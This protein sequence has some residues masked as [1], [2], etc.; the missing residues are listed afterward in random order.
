MAASKD[1]AMARSVLDAPHLQSEEAAFEYI[2]RLIWPNGP[3][4]PWSNKKTGE[5]CASK[6]QNVVKLTVYAKPKKDGTRSLRHG[7]YRCKHCR[8][9]FTVRKGTVF[10]ETQ[11]PMHLWL[12]VIHLMNSS[13]KGIAT[14]QVQRLLNCSME[15]AWFLTH[16]VREMM[17]PGESSGPNFGGSGVT[18]EADETYVGAVAGKKK[19][20]PPVEKMPVVSLVERGGA[21]RSFHVPNV[22]AENV[23]TILVSHARRQSVLNTDDSPLYVQIGKGFAKHETVGHTYGEYVRGTTHTNTVEGFFSILKRGL[24]GVY[25]HVSEAHLQKYLHEFDFRYTNRAALGIDDATRA[26]LTVRGAKGKRL[27]YA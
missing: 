5:I 10:E 26:A 19:F 27:T 11:L 8:G 15:T 6:P 20:R 9:Q 14:R 17:K 24:F 25:Q 23:G 3:V 7:L 13:K 4:C 2:E 18:I 12:Q 1:I 16:R 22:R 21:V